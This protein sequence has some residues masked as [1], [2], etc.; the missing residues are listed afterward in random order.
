M[1]SSDDNGDGA[2]FLLMAICGLV[3]IFV[4]ADDDQRKAKPAP[5]PQTETCPTCGKVKEA[6]DGK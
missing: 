6:P 3:A 4:F 2:F 1:A 5:P